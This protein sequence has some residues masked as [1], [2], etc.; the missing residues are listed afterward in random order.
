MPWHV[1][2]WEGLQL[3]GKLQWHGHT[4]LC[5]PAAQQ[6]D[7]LGGMKNMWGRGCSGIWHSGMVWSCM[8]KCSSKATPPCVSILQH[9]TCN[10]TRAGK[11]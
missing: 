1:L 10:R 5:Q 3:H 7:A 4:P 9:D 11:G 8:V 2:S 6:I